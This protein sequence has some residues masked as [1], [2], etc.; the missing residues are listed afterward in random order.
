MTGFYSANNHQSNSQYPKKMLIIEDDQNDFLIVKN[1]I[2]NK[3]SNILVL[4]ATSLEDAY[5]IYQTHK[6]DFILLDLNLPDGHGL[7]SIQ[8][9]KRFHG[10][11]PIIAMT[12]MMTDTIETKAKKMGASD[13]ISKDDLQTQVFFDCLDKM[14]AKA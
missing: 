11:T 7:G 5:K 3:Y 10:Q 8:E 6:S 12:G 9:L 1:L 13:I 2:M 4:H 14:G